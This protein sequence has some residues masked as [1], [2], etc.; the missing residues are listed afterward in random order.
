MKKIQLTAI[1]TIFTIIGIFAQGTV[2]YSPFQ[3][4]L[5]PPLGTNGMHAANTVN[6]F[7]LNIF[8]G[9]SAGVQGIEVGSFV[10]IERDFVKGIQLAGFGSINAGDIQSMQFSGFFNVN[11]GSGIAIQSAGF[12]NLNAGDIKGIETAGFFNTSRD[13]TG[14]QAAG[15]GNLAGKVEG[16]QAGGFFNIS[17]DI[18]GGQAAGFVNRAKNVLGGQAAGFVNLAGDVQGGQAAGFVNLAEDVEGGQAAGFINVARN[19]KGF[20]I[21]GFINICDSID[22]VPIAVV[23]IVRKNGYRKIEISSDETFYLNTSLKMGV[24]KFYTSITLGM[25]TNHAKNYYSYGFGAGTNIVFDPKKSLSIE[26]Q[27]QQLFDFEFESGSYDHELNRLKALFNYHYS[28]KLCLFAGPTINLLTSGKPEYTNA[29]RPSWAF[30]I[31]DRKYS[32]ADA[33]FGF[34]A[35]LRFL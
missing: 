2:R 23:S 29:I 5:F 20:Q 35:G 9:V 19:V 24:E 34:S 4:S 12:V 15:F 18:T 8:T 26:Y 21:A 6:Y 7:S 22:G 1:L 11:K 28:K 33:W 32:R 3:V 31:S 14:I 17:G 30:E 25:R 16:G 27:M 13:F 10:N